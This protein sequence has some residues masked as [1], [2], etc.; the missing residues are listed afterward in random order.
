MKEQKIIYI[1]GL[2]IYLLFAIGSECLY[3]NKLYDESVKYEE[4]IDQDGFWHHFFYFWAMIFLYSS[5]GIGII[6]TL[7]FYP[8]NITFS[9]FSI[10][11]L[12][13]FTMCMLKSIYSNPRP[14]WDIYEGK[15]GVRKDKFQPEPTECDGGFGNPSGHA[16]IST[17]LLCLWDLFI[18][19]TRFNKFQGTKKTFIKYFSL[20][21]S[22]IFMFFIIKFCLEQF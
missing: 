1:I 9:Y 14:Y 16:L 13:T 8:I 7:F 15:Q 5:M 2:I 20:S 21:L 18:N 3:R 22:I 4:D 6:I 11:M 17:Y 10:P 12:L 19:S